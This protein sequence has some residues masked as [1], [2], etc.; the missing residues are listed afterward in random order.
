MT[1]RS[2]G[3]VTGTE[4]GDVAAVEAGIVA[5]VGEAGVGVGRGGGA[6]AAG[7]ESAARTANPRMTVCVVI[8]QQY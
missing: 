8:L 5:I 1:V 4:G 6:A 2:L 3:T 7:K